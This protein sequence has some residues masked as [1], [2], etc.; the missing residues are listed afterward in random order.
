MSVTYDKSIKSTGDSKWGYSQ[1][2]IKDKESIYISLN[3]KHLKIR[4]NVNST[5]KCSSI[6]SNVIY[7]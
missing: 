4:E 1:L 5:T 6:K 7:E 3:L 2:S